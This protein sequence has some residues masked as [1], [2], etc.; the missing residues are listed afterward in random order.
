METPLGFQALICREAERSYS[1]LDF[2]SRA[3][4]SMQASGLGVQWGDV[5]TWVGSVMTG[6]ALLVAATAYRKS[7]R[8][9]ERTQASMVT[10]W[11]KQVNGAGTVHVKNSSDASVYAVTIYY[12]GKG[13]SKAI[14]PYYLVRKKE[15]SLKGLGRWPS[16]GPGEEESA[17]F[18]RSK[19]FDPEIPWLYFRDANGVDWTRDYRARLKRHNYT[20]A[21]SE[22]WYLGKP[23]G[24]LWWIFIIGSAAEA[25]TKVF[26]R[27]KNI[28]KR[29][30]RRA[31]KPED[32]LPSS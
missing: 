6:V 20:Q 30:T 3:G 4:D 5:P 14:S 12:G 21:L 15:S 19:V 25:I 23:V 7:V 28:F 22:L 26:N 13:A 27:V 17:P 11:V 32:E 31:V 8:D 29:Q 2:G 10:I 16:I 24:V 9:T 1:G 18:K